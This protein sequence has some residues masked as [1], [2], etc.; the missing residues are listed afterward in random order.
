MKPRLI[1]IHTMETPE[2]V[3]RAKQ[4]WRWFASKFSPQASPHYLTDAFAVEQSVLETDTAWAV[5]DRS[6]NQ[7]SIS[8]ELSG[9]ASQTPAQWADPYSMAELALV[10]KLAAA[11]SKRH[12]IPTVH[13]TPGQILSGKSGFC[14]HNDITVAKKIR[15][16]HTDPGTNFPWTQF[17]ALVAIERKKLK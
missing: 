13:L 3:G 4:V 17:L 1:V 6:L 11:I 9:M 14:G 15:G 16:G 10:A 5:D 8:I 12:N 2:T 7:A